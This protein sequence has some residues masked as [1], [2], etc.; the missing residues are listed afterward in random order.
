MD[1]LELL[2]KH[3][4]FLPFIPLGEAGTLW[5]HTEKTMK[6]KIDAGDIRLPYFTPDGKQKSVKLVRLE[7]V[8][9]ILDQRATDADKEFQKLW[10]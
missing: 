8:A 5:G 3:F 9:K 10:S 4:N 2:L 6:E 1:T 7:T